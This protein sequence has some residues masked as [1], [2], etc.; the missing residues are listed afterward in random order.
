MIEEVKKI[1]DRFTTSRQCH[2]LTAK[3][4]SLSLPNPEGRDDT[5]VDVSAS[6]GDILQPTRYLSR[7]LRDA[8]RSA[9]R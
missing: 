5:L 4:A 2:P 3:A 6:E 9:L 8:W 7:I 1:L